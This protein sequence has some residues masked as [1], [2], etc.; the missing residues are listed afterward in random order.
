MCCQQGQALH[1]EFEK[2]VTARIKA[3]M[4]FHPNLHGQVARTKKQEDIALLNRSMHISK[5]GECWQQP[6][7]STDFPGLQ[8][9]DPAVALKRP[10]ARKNDG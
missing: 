4:L 9:E 10:S 2:A 3:E 7:R 6:P 8:L 1:P 5:C